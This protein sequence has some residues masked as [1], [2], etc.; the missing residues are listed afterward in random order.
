MEKKQSL[1]QQEK[2]NPNNIDLCPV[3]EKNLYYNDRFT[4]RVAIVDHNEV[5]G[6]LCPFCSCEIDLKDNLVYNNHQDNKAGKA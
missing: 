4:R 1:S 3:C 5:D 2:R 6:W